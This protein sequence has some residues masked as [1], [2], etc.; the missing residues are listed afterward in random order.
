MERWREGLARCLR[1][2]AS[3]RKEGPAKRWSYYLFYR[4]MNAIS[5]IEIH[6]IAAIFA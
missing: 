3:H 2:A 6:S 5:D 1:N 4:I